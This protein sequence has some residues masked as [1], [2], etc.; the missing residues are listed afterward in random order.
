M[1]EYRSRDTNMYSFY[2]SWVLSAIGQMDG[3]AVFL[4]T[5][6]PVLVFP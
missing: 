6:I 1:I 2:C 4:D 3:Q 5:P